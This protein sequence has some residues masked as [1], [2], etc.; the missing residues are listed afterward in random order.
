MP[1]TPEV[2]VRSADKAERRVPL[3]AKMSIGRA[4]DSDI[5]FPD[6]LL[7]RRHAEIDLRSD[8]TYIIDLEST[9]GTFLNGERLYHEQRLR[10]G[11]VIAVGSNT[12]V[13]CEVEAVDAS[14]R[15]AR[16]YSLNE[17]SAR[18]TRKTIDVTQ[19][20]K[21]DRVLGSLSR[22]TSALVGISNLADIY[23][24]L[25][26]LVL[27]VIP[28]ERGAIMMLEGTQGA[29]RV[30]AARSRVGTEID[31]V[32]SSIARKVVE[33]KMSVLLRDVF[34][35]IS[36]KDQPSIVADPIRAAMCAPLWLAA[37]P[38]EQGTVLGFVY[39]DSHSRDPFSESDLQV[40]TVLANFAATKIESVRLAQE[41]M[42]KRRLEEDMRLAAE[43]QASL[44]PQ[45]APHVAGHDVGGV[46]RPS[47]AVGGDY[48]D[49]MIDGDRLH[50]ALGDVSGKGLGAAMLMV[51]LRATVR[52]YWRDDQLAPAVARMNEIFNQSVPFDKYAT[53]FVGRLD[54]P[55]GR[56][57]YVNAGHNQP[58]LVR[59]VGT[60]E[61]LEEGGTILGAFENG[62]WSEGNVTLMPGD[63]LVIFSDGISDLWPDAGLA[64]R[65]LTELVREHHARSITTLQTAIFAETDRLGGDRPQDVRTLLL[66]RRTS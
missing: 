29:P 18:A 8:G 19:L 15:A 11:D 44:L 4:E 59:A 35:D 45:A 51:A 60:V 49:F 9:N 21:D 13:F 56:L 24:G 27:E 48:Y 10:D 57:T 41:N 47:R 26:D 6:Q 65:R 32:S 40:L 5:Y 63:T 46:T 20:V 37:N 55:S 38:G 16:Y 52:S 3:R 1:R 7:S 62:E 30:K 39:L 64:D 58:L 28:A 36:L 42:E 14:D 43:I 61:R 12:L 53:F 22:V 31:H 2:R 25:L 34:E 54:T 66:V 50:I 33:G 17:L 23:T